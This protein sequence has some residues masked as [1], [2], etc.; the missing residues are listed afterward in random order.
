MN[1]CN[2]QD[3]DDGDLCEADIINGYGIH[4]DE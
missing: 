3:D 1:R 2:S 4:P